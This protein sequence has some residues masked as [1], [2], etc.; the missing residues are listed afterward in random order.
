MA[1]IFE[2]ISTNK[3]SEETIISMIKEEPTILKSPDTPRDSTNHTLLNRASRKNKKKVIL[4]LLDLG[5][6]SYIQA[7]N[8][9]NSLMWICNHLQYD[10]IIRELQ[11]PVSIIS[12]RD[13]DGWTIVDFFLD[14]VTES[15]PIEIINY[16]MLLFRKLKMN[17]HQKND[18]WELIN[19]NKNISRKKLLEIRKLVIVYNSNN[20][21]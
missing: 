7:N 18:L 19:N 17:N 13:N 4:F 6:C 20:D 10:I 8:G 2:A 3:V 21:Y 5:A 14:G 11:N 9:I 16:F 12:L 15:T 1:A